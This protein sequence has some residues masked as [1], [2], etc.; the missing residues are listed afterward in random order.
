M[1]GS[2]LLYLGHVIFSIVCVSTNNL[3]FSLQIA[4][5]SDGRD[6]NH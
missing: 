3:S 1:I 6:L 4:E 2:M 5:E